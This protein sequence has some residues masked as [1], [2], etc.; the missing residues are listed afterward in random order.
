MRVPHPK[1]FS[2]TAVL[3]EQPDTRLLRAVRI[4]DARPV[5]LKQIRPG[6]SPRALARLKNE[7]EFQSRLRSR[8]VLEAYALETFQELPTLVLEDFGGRS[9]DELLVA[10]LPVDRFLEL[11]IPIAGAVAEVHRQGIVHRDLKPANILVNT[12]SGETKIADFGIASRVPRKQPVSQRPLLIEGSLAY[13]SPEQ[14]G[15]VNRAV[16]SRS[17]LYSLGITFYRMLTGALPFHAEDPMEWVHAH[18]AIMPV[19]P[20]ELVPGLPQALSDVV[21]RLLAKAPEERYQSALGLRR[22]LEECRRRWETG[23]R[24]EPFPLGEH[25]LPDRLC[26][27]Q[28]LYGRSGE[29]ATLLAAFERVKRRGAPELVAVSGPAGIGKSALVRELQAPIAQARG[30]FTSGRFDQQRR[31]I[32]YSAIVQALGALV[33]DLLTESEG[34]VSSLRQALEEALGP[35]ARLIASVIPEVELILGKPP[36]V[37]EPPLA[38]APTGFDQAFLQFLGVLTS[39]SRPLV[40]FLD[41]LHWADPASLRL[42][43]H[44]LTRPEATHLVVIG[45]FR[46]DELGPSHALRT[47]LEELRRTGARTVEIVL[48]PLS[49]EDVGR[50]VADTVRCSPETAASLASLV[51]EKSAGNPLLAI[52]FLTT[53]QR[54]GLLELDPRTG[55]W[56]WDLE[57]IRSRAFPKNVADLVVKKLELLPLATQ[58]ALALASCAGN[59]VDA[60]T[61]A[62]AADASLEATHGA[63]LAAV[64]EG[65]LLRLDEQTYEF[66]HDN[67]RQAVYERLP[68]DRRLAAHEAVGRLLLAKTTPEAVPEAVF[69]I[70]NQLNLGA[71]PLGSAEER[72]RGAELNLLAGKKAKAEAAYHSAATYLSSGIAQLSPESWETDDE[73][74]SALHLE[75]AECERR[76]GDLD[77]AERLVS[78]VLKHARSRVDKAAAYRALSDLHGARSELGTALSY[79]LEGLRLLGIDLPAHPTEQQ[80]RAEYDE[81]SAKLGKRDIESLIDLPLVADRKVQAALRIL[82]SLRGLASDPHL[83][84]LHVCRM[85]NVCLEHGNTDASVYAYGAFGV[86]LCLLFRRY[87]D[88]IEFGKLGARL[89]EKHGYL[90]SRAQANLSL[91]RIAYWTQPVPVA[92]NYAVGAVDAGI[93]SGDGYAVGYACAQAVTNILT[94]GDRLEDVLRESDE[95]LDHARRAKQPDA[96]KAIIETQRYIQ[97]LRGLTTTFSSL[98]DADFDA[99][100]F[101]KN[102]GENPTILCWHAIWKLQTRVMSG[103]FQGAL[104]ASPDAEQLFWASLSPSRTHDYFFYHALA[105]AGFHA[106]ASS[107][108]QRENVA[109]LREHAA[110]LEEWTRRCPSTFSCTHALVAAEIARIEGRTEEAMRSYEDAIRSAREHGF[111]QNEAIAYEVASRFY[112]ERGYGT[113]ADA[114]VHE[115]IGCYSRWGAEGKVRQLTRLFPH[116]AEPRTL[117]PSLTFAM[118]AEQFDLL[119][120]VKAS[121]SISSQIQLTKLRE[122][123]LQIV[124]EHAG[125]EKGAVVLGQAGNYTVYANGEAVPLSPAV[126]PVSVIDHVSRTLETVILDATAPSPFSS[127]EYLVRERPRS[128]LCM[129]IVRRAEAVGMLYLENNLFAGAFSRDKLAVLE[130]IATQAAVSIENATLYSEL[131]H[132]QQLIEAALKTRDTFLSVASHE[133]RTPLTSL[134]LQIQS[135]RRALSDP[136]RPEF[137]FE[138]VAESLARADRQ[139]KRLSGLVDTTLDIS[140]LQTKGVMLTPETVDLGDIV[141]EVLESLGDQLGGVTWLGTQSALGFWDRL[142]LWQVVTNLVTNAI[143]FGAGKPVEI[144]LEDRPESVRLSVRDHGIGIA[145]ADHERIFNAFERA[146]SPRHYGGLGLGLHISQRFVE[147]HG[148]SLTVESEEGAGSTFTVTLPRRTASS[149]DPGEGSDSH[150]PLSPR[151]PLP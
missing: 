124:L 146:V 16:D 122:T 81:V 111:V 52:Q 80:V 113:F 143:K 88:G 129:P 92:I 13:V 94:R 115:A 137:S 14:T 59:T 66:A 63:L 11:A 12:V 149:T 70:A 96:V 79:A 43:T 36:P 147:A 102:L 138:R 73:L 68:A 95:W 49:R 91:G 60:A 7:F 69:E 75:Q 126:L 2:V 50:L 145:P 40:L 44:V 65:L 21:L 72:R 3:A 29:V 25:G 120:V 15:R 35:S 118:E 131:Q 37:P 48:E 83:M 112:R 41:D 1:K 117:A 110:Q 108:A 6:A 26:V 56:T 17:D 86:L 84:V 133:L 20:G 61:V 132:R 128:M 101:E 142:K 103:D 55:A 71:G 82:S 93:E 140:R 97:N 90:G 22:D 148:G 87:D 123:L 62:R 104:A 45:A 139:L 130:L 135:L 5:V 150:S 32:P 78:V 89:V 134:K 105:L 23:R 53:V 33:P 141:R 27:P 18:L 106:E 67:V 107:S 114:Y 144:V 34:R 24:I 136:R 54:E 125:A 57:R 42:L 85:V 74:A 39:A 58:E 30:A 8:S 121:Q 98:S 4:P 76:D 47:T 31:G 119:S 51:H 151:A 109:R 116:V 77:A 9:L 38:E 10:P 46:D 100:D 127:D 19:A 99:D 28:A 64:D